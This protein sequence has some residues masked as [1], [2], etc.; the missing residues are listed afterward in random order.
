MWAISWVDY[1]DI[2]RPNVHEYG[3]WMICCTKLMAENNKL[4]P[5]DSQRIQ[6]VRVQFVKPKRKHE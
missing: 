4:I 6:Q 2:K 1:N 5:K 3:A